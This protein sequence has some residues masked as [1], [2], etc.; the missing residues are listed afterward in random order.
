VDAQYVLTDSNVALLGTVVGR[1]AK[2]NLVLYRI[3][4]PAR[5]TTSITGWYPPPDNWT[6]PHTTWTRAQCTGGTLRLSI[7]G[8]PN[9]F[10]GVTQHVRISGTTPTRT[11]VVPGPNAPLHVVVPLTPH[12]GTC[13]VRLDPS[14]VRKPKG[15]PRTLG[16]HALGFAYTP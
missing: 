7:Y 12:G 13:V 10:K 16:V 1:D 2:R 5:V 11:Y 9:L 6:G 4:Q 3:T 14:P 8:D 15:D